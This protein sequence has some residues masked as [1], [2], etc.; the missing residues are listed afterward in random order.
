VSGADAPISA[1]I[2]AGTG[3]IAGDDPRLGPLAANGGFG[4]TMLP[5]AGSPLL[6]A[7][8]TTLGSPATDQ[9]GLARVSGTA[10][11]LGAVEVQAAQA[12]Q[13]E[14]AATG[15]ATLLSGTLG[16]LALLGGVLA[17]ATRRRQRA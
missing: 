1:A 17:L 16:I 3:N 5:L 14:L 11:D 15:P 4:R 7:G 9:R 2:A 8:A 6:D 13:H 10:A 12:A